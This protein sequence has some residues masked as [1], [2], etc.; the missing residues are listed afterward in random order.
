M[1]IDSLIVMP[2]EGQMIFKL[3]VAAFLGAIIGYEREA[4]DRPAGLR[5]HML[6]TMGAAVFAMISFYAFP[7]DADSGR[8]ASYVVVGIG[9]IGAGTVIQLKNKVVGLTTA[10]SLWLTAAIGVSVAIG[11][12]FLA[13]F[14]AAIG[15]IVLSLTPVENLIQRRRKSRR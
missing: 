3:L 7:A 2:M 8:M 10:S 6:V 11:Y 4:R 14:A 12:Y 13:A 15:F 5:T 1:V 9:F